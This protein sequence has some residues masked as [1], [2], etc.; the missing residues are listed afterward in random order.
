MSYREVAPLSPGHPGLH[1]SRWPFWGAMF[2]VSRDNFWTGEERTISKVQQLRR[3]APG[4]ND[5]YTYECCPICRGL[6]D[7]VIKMDIGSSS[8]RA[9]RVGTRR[10]TNPRALADAVR[11]MRGHSI[12][13]LPPLLRLSLHV[14][15]D[16]QSR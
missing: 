7:A 15:E 14:A 5:R 9:I 8:A 13:T 4:D 6:I 3:S 16:L 12:I 1:A 11:P 2:V 10:P